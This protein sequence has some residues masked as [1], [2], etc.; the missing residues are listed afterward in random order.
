MGRTAPWFRVSCPRHR[1]RSPAAGVELAELN[2]LLDDQPGRGATMLIWAIGG[3][4]GVGKTWLGLRWAHDNLEP[5][6]DG[7]LYIDMRGFDPTSEPLSPEAAVRGFLDALGV[8]PAA[9][10]ADPDAQVGLYR[11]LVAG[12]R[13]LVVLDNARDTARSH[14]VARCTHLHGVDYQPAQLTSLVTAHGAAAMALDVLTAS[15]ANCSPTA[16]CGS[17]GRR[18][19]PVRALL[20]GAPACRWRSASSP[21]APPF[22]RVPSPTWPASCARRPPG[23]DALDAGELAVTYERCWPARAR[24]SRPRQRDCSGYS[25]SCRAPT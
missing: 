1:G 25:A 16:G 4:G 10:P 17:R 20:I 22:A 12:Q 5:F 11:S 18:A 13:M 23:L 8:P 9:V 21:P 24:R 15:E 2:R 19:G 3:T 6:P 7:Q 14:P